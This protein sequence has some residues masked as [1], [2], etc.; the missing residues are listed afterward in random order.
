M[1]K[2]MHLFNQKHS[3]LKKYI[4]KIPKKKK[5]FYFNEFSNVIYSGNG[6][7]EFSAVFTLPS[8]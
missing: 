3:D 1:L 4:I 7:A 8:L 6:K 2:N 5:V